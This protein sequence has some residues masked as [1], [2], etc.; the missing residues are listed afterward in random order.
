MALNARE[1]RIVVETLPSDI[2]AGGSAT[3]A[4]AHAPHRYAGPKS[5]FLGLARSF[6]RLAGQRAYRAVAL[7]GAELAIA[8][9]AAVSAIAI[10]QSGEFW[11]W[12]PEFLIAGL[13]LLGS[14]LVVGLATRAFSGR[15]RY[16]GVRDA[17]IVT[18]AGVLAAVLAFGLFALFQLTIALTGNY[19]FFNLLTLALCV[20]LLDDGALIRW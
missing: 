3:P 5:F 14:K 6:D 10:I 7:V 1:N 8:F 12:R 13:I 17:M 9:V 20:P 16:V 19:T 11:R 2:E 15:W 4:V 18:R